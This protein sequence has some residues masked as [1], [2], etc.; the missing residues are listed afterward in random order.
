MDVKMLIKHRKDLE[1][2]GSELQGSPSVQRVVGKFCN[3]N[4]QGAYDNLKQLSDQELR[5]LAVIIGKLNDVFA[6]RK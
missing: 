6:E 5:V 3:V 1:K 2:L 4:A